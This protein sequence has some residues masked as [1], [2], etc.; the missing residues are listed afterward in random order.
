[1]SDWLTPETLPSADAVPGTLQ[2]RLGDH[3]ALPEALFTLT[4]LSELVIDG[5][6]L[7]AIPERIARLTNLTSITVLSSQALVCPRELFCLPHLTHL[8]IRNIGTLTLPEKVTNLSPLTELRIV[9][10]HLRDIPPWIAKLRMTL[11]TLDLS[12]NELREIVVDWLKFCELRSVDVSQNWLDAAAIEEL[13]D[14]IWEQGAK[15]RKGPQLVLEP[16]R[17]PPRSG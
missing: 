17:K 7:A 13:L 12:A 1:V 5:T 15:C 8:V 3:Q 9:N 11:R 10:A 16:Q 14:Q 4:S 2:V 6:R